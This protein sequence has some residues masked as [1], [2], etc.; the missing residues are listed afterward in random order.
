MRPLL[1]NIIIYT[2]VAVR[3]KIDTVGEAEEHIAVLPESQ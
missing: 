2:Y 1:Y 3:T